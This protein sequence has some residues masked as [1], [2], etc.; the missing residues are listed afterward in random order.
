VKGIVLRKR[1]D[2]ERRGRSGKVVSAQC[3]MITKWPEV[4]QR[5]ERWSGCY[6]KSSVDGV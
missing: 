2:V 5:Q 4:L 6:D 3:I 1:G